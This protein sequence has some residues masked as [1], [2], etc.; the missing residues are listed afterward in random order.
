MAME[1]VHGEGERDVRLYDSIVMSRGAPNLD[2]PTDGR[3]SSGGPT[4]SNCNLRASAM[5]TV[6]SYQIMQAQVANPHGFYVATH[7]YAFKVWR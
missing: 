5:R 2:A 4:A 7:R 3:A 1:V 6:R